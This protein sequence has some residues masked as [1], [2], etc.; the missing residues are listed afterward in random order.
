[1]DPRVSRS[2]LDHGE[3]EVLALALE[4]GAQRV[5]LDDLPARLLAWRL[6]L[7]VVGTLG[8]AV[9]AKREGAI[10]TIEPVFDAL[11]ATGFRVSRD[12]LEATLAAAGERP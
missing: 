11:V 4:L 8:V 10:P 7:P 6:D 12:V 1:M 2:R 3:R 5:V 9:I